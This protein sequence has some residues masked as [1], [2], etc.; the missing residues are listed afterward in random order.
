MDKS[1]IES[2]KEML[3]QHLHLYESMPADAYISL[4]G[5]LENKKLRECT[6]QSILDA[7]LTIANLGLNPDPGLKQVH[8][9]PTWDG[10]DK[11]QK[12][13]MIIGYSGFI[14]LLQRAGYLYDCGDVICEKDHFDFARGDNPTFNHKINLNDRG[15]VIG[16][17]VCFISPDGRKMVEVIE[18]EDIERAMKSSPSRNKEGK[19]VGPWISHYREMVK[20]TAIRRFA[21]KVPFTERTASLHEALK[22][23][24]LPEK[25]ATPE[26][27]YENMPIIKELRTALEEWK[28]NQAGTRFAEAAIESIRSDWQNMADSGDAGEDVIN[29]GFLLISEANQE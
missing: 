29:H 17:Y 4:M 13:N 14:T 9:I 2:N 15:A 19:L 21:K 18:K 8:L 20:K 1:I 7:A 22:E 28:A 16:A 23:D 10:K 12:V 27:N 11:S 26:E 24:D 3:V 5:A 25:D 6:K